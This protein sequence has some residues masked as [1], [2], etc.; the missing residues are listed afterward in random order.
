[1]LKLRCS[2]HL[3]ARDFLV[4]CCPTYST[5]GISSSSWVQFIAI[6]NSGIQITH[7]HKGDN[8]PLR[9]VV[10]MFQNI[11]VNIFCMR[12]VI[13]TGITFCVSECIVSLC[14]QNT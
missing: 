4:P 13:S 1:M 2:H 11:R 9:P 6:V 5:T 7:A 8:E 12:S 14:T 10:V 3:A